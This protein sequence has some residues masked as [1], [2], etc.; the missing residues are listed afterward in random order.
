MV[1]VQAEAYDSPPPSR[2]EIQRRRARLKQG[3][4]FLIARDM[5]TG[6]VVGAGSCSPIVD[7]VTEVAAIGVART[8]RRRGIAQA[9]CRC[10]A[11]NAFASGA[12]VAYLMAVNEAERR[13]YERVGFAVVSEMLHI[14]R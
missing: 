14:S 1:V 9:L 6:Q 11:G 5:H 4:I 10:L 2:E 8:H 13:I 7:D 12:G 3:A